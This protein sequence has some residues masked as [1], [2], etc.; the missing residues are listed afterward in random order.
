MRRSARGEEITMLKKAG[1]VGMVVAMCAVAFGLGVSSA[2]SG[3]TAPFTVD[4]RGAR[5]DRQG[6]RRREEG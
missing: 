6:R 1:L 3:I 5:D 2:G 4:G